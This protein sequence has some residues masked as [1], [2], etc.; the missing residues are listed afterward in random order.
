MAFLEFQMCVDV[1]I[2]PITF[3]NCV[4]TTPYIL[5]TAI[6]HRLRSSSVT[7]M[8]WPYLP[9]GCSSGESAPFCRTAIGVPVDL[10]Y[11]F[12]NV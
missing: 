1:V 11:S 10:L 12:A 2:H 5:K 7:A 9:H 3:T 6:L 4:R 8:L